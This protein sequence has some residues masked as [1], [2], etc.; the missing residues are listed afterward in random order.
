M[1]T[2]PDE[3]LNAYRRDFSALERQFVDLEDQL[4]QTVEG[5]LKIMRLALAGRCEHEDEEKRVIIEDSSAQQGF[6][7][8][9]IIEGA[10]G[11]TK[12]LPFIVP[13]AVLPCSAR[14][15]EDEE[16][17]S[18]AFRKLTADIQLEVS[19]SRHL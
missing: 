3:Y 18:W 6:R 4:G 1:A 14:K 7:T 12:T 15:I 16:V 8:E 10:L 2:H 17:S 9:R 19:R 13:W 5:R 11:I